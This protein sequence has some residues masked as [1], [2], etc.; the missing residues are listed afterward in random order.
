MF[1]R[2]ALFVH[3]LSPRVPARVCF[4]MLCRERKQ[5]NNGVPVFSVWGE[6]WE[7]CFNVQHTLSSWGQHTFYYPQA[8]AARGA[9]TLTWPW[10][11]CVFTVPPSLDVL[12]SLSH[13]QYV[14]KAVTDT[15]SQEGHSG[16]SSRCNAPPQFLINDKANPLALLMASWTPELWEKEQTERRLEA[17]EE[18]KFEKEGEKREKE[19]QNGETAWKCEE[20]EFVHGQ[21]GVGSRGDPD[22]LICL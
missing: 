16:S 11:S 14:D 5:Q 17:K 19:S 4:D 9:A 7:P 13:W 10:L 8:L 15:S 18:E 21:R 3:S 20:K 1:L 12:L 6:V 22:R 2:T